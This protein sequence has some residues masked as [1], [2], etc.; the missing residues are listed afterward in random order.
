MPCGRHAA[1][2]PSRR[3]CTGAGRMSCGA[4]RMPW[5]SCGCRGCRA[6]AVGVL[7]MPCGAARM[8]CG[9]RAD[10]VRMPWVCCGCRAVPHGCR[11][12]PGRCCGCC[13]YAVHPRTSLRAFPMQ[14]PCIP[15]ASPGCRRLFQHTTEC[16]LRDPQPRKLPRSC[17]APCCVAGRAGGLNPATP[18]HFV[19]PCACPCTSCVAGSRLRRVSLG[20]P[21]IPCARPR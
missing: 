21:F 13:T 4:V 14:N 8:P 10:A 5:V 7:R 20:V 12:D 11:A 2:A 15:L 16:R 19:H 6:D 3:P 1:A 17:L 18:C 9:C